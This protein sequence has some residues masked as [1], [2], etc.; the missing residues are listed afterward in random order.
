MTI[1]KI[2]RF[3]GAATSREDVVRLVNE[4]ALKAEMLGIGKKNYVK[5]DF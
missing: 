4:D 5:F 1:G 2:R 3:L